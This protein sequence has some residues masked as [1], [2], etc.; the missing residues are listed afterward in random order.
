MCW[1]CAEH[2]ERYLHAFVTSFLD[3]LTLIASNTSTASSWNYFTDNIVKLASANYFSVPYRIDYDVD[4]GILF[5]YEEASEQ[6]RI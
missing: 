1:R 4:L 5:Q 6:S 3:Y 2:V